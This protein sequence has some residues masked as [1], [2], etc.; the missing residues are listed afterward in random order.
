MDAIKHSKKTWRK[1]SR[2]HAERRDK[3]YQIGIAIEL[4]VG[5]IL[6]CGVVSDIIRLLTN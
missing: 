3:A 1:Y 6:I 4:F 2:Y 5:W